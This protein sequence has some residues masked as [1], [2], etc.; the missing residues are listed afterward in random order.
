MRFFGPAKVVGTNSYVFL[1]CCKYCL[2]IFTSEE[3]Y[4]FFICP[5]PHKVFTVGKTIVVFHIHSITSGCFFV[6]WLGGSLTPHQ[7]M[8]PSYIICIIY[9]ITQQGDPLVSSHHKEKIMHPTLQ[10]DHF[11]FFLHDG[12]NGISCNVFFFYFPLCMF[13]A[14]LRNMSTRINKREKLFVFLY[15]CFCNNQIRQFDEKSKF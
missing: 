8:G 12:K 3:F 13:F 14:G 7:R 6:D 1:L 11:A 9:N 10:G 4:D 2:L 15:T 5:A